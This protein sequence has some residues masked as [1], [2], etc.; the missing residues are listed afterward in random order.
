MSIIYALRCFRIYLLGLKFKII[1]DCQA[2][3]LTLKKKETNP[4]IARWTLEMQSYDYQLEH[5]TGLRMLYVDALSRQLCI[6]ED[7]SFLI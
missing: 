7:N 6:V 2:L 3:N 4:R 5:R 1:T